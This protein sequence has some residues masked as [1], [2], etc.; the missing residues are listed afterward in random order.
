MRSLLSL[1]KNARKG[2]FFIMTALAVVTVLFFVG[3]WSDPLTQIDTSNI[4]LSD[5]LFT[6]DN[7][8]EKT[9]EVVKKSA[10]CEDLAY[11]LQEYKDFISDFSKTK[12]YKIDFIYSMGSCI[13]GNGAT[14]SFK[15]RVQSEQ[16]NAQKDF[17]ITWP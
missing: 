11:N 10:N 9:T 15:M 3:R 7:L 8:Y 1:K 16:S 2:Q 14:I 17:I 5:E 12:N 13:D 4:V 6:F